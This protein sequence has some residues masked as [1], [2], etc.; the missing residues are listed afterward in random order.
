MLGRPQLSKNEVVASEE[1]EEE[2]EVNY[3]IAI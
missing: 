1:E 3:C 2:E